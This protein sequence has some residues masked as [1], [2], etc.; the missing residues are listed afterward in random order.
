MRDVDFL[1]FLD[2][3]LKAQYAYSTIGHV[4]SFLVHQE[5]IRYDRR[6]L[7]GSLRVKKALKRYQRLAKA[8]AKDTK[9]LGLPELKTILASTAPN[10]FKS[11][12]VVAFLFA[13]RHNEV[14]R[15]LTGEN[16][17]EK[18]ATG[19]KLRLFQT[20]TNKAPRG[21]SVF[22]PASWIP[23]GA[24]QWLAYA[25]RAP[26][27]GLVDYAAD[28]SRLGAL[29]GKPS[30]VRFHG[31]RHGRATQLRDSGVP[32]VTIQNFGRWK[33]VETVRVYIH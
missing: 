31:W 21:V 27:H 2:D 8:Y 3:M 5:I 6:V 25:A 13:L 30:E 16:K 14:H 23:R 22:L 24:D 11:K 26:L 32:E 29:L 7:T 10:V 20:K 12:C 19:W 1:L 9:P 4:R 15:V 28:N 17:L 33:R 18:T